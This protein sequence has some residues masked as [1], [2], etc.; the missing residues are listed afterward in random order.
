METRA[1]RTAHLP[2]LT[3]SQ[4]LDFDTRETTSWFTHV[5][6]PLHQYTAVTAAHHMTV[7]T[8]HPLHIVG[9][10]SAPKAAAET[11]PAYQDDS[12]FHTGHTVAHTNC[13]DTPPIEV[14]T[15]STH[16]HT[17]LPPPTSTGISLRPHTP[18]SRVG[19]TVR[20]QCRQASQRPSCILSLQAGGGVPL[21][22]KNATTR[23]SVE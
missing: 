16:G 5:L 13:T 12:I 23:G 20:L 22:L 3:K 11:D 15:S 7:L 18:A 9:T 1:Q 4:H 10:I 14:S 6:R 19:S 2:S 21:T 17:S 8:H